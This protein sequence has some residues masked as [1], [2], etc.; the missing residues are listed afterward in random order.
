MVYIEQHKNSINKDGLWQVRSDK[1]RE[2]H[3]N[4]AD[5]MDKLRCFITE[6]SQPAHEPSQETLEIIRIRREKAAQE[7]LK[8]KRM[9]SSLKRDRQLTE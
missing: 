3:I 5:C 1:T 6:A 9:R 7:R 4:L 8:N 2:Q